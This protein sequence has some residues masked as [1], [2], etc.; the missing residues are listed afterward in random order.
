M[1]D[2]KKKH[3]HT[4]SGEQ[5]FCWLKMCNEMCAD[6]ELTHFNSISAIA[7]LHLATVQ[8]HVYLHLV[9]SSFFIF[10]YV[11]I[12]Q[13][14]FFSSS[15]CASISHWLYLC[16]VRLMVGTWTLFHL[17]QLNCHAFGLLFISFHSIFYALFC[18]SSTFFFRCSVLIV[19]RFY[20][21]TFARHSLMRALAYVSPSP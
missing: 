20:F 13:S 1:D 17:K 2:C 14:W 10:L 15:G 9:S 7:L 3:A 16:R 19:R 18:P 5:M 11:S 4:L 12:R 21:S 8:L 6:K